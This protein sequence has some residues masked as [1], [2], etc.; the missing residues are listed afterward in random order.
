M[1]KEYGLYNKFFDKSSCGVGFITRKDG[2]QTHDIIEKSH[3]ALCSV[4]HRGGMS[5]EGVG[6]GA[7]VSIDL[8]K[9]FFSKITSKE[10]KLGEFCVGNFF[11][12]NNRRFHN[13]AVNLIEKILINKKMKFLKSRIIPVNMKILGA[14][15]RKLQLSIKQWI[16]ET[17]KNLS[18]KDLEKIT[19]EALLEIEKEAFILKDFEGLY[20]LSLSTKTQVLK[21]RLNSNELI[22]YFLDLQ[23]KKH[24][25]SS[26]YFHTRFSTNT[27][28][29]P[30]M[31]QPFRLMAHNGELN[32]DNKNR[33]S[34]NAIYKAK[35]KEIIR[36]NGQSDSCRFDQTLKNRI[37]EDDL[38][39]VSAIVCMMPP[40]WENNKYL[41]KKV[42]AMFEYFSLYEEKNDGPAAVIFGDGKIVGACLDRLGL[43]PLR[44]VET[45]DYISVMS[46]SGQIRFPESTVIERGRIEAGGIRY[47]D[48][49]KKKLFNTLETYELL[50]KEKDYIT[51]LKEHSLKISELNKSKISKEKYNG[52][53]NVSARYVAYYHNQESLKF[54]ID[55]ILEKGVEKVSAMGYGNAINAL[56]PSEG[57]M[58]KYFSHRFAQVTNPPLDPIRESD[59]MSLRVA[60]GPK[61]NMKTKKIPQIVLDSPLLNFE[62]LS[63]IKE[64]KVTPIKSFD[65]TF[66]PN[67]RDYKKNQLAITNRLKELSTQIN[68]FVKKDGGIV[69]L[70]DREIS[71]EK[72]AI[73][74]ILTVSAINQGLIS[75]GL[76]FKTSIIVESGQISSPHHVA[77]ALGFGGS[78]VYSICSELRGQDKF[79]SDLEQSQKKFIKACEKSL[80]KI[81]G[82]V[83]LC[84]V[85]S[86]S[87]GEFFEPN[88]LNTE[89]SI[90]KIF[91]PNL[92]SPVGGVG[93]SE[94]AQSIADW[95]ERSKTISTEKDIP[96][97]GLFK[98]RTE[99]AGHSFGLT[100]VKG[101]LD[102]T[103]EKVLQDEKK[104][105]D[106]EENMRLLTLNKMYDSFG[107]N[108]KNFKNTTFEKLTLKQINNFKI[109]PG[110]RSFSKLMNRERAE[111]PA[112]LR[113]ILGFPKDINKA[114]NKEDFVSV[115]NYYNKIGNN[116]Y[117]IKNLSVKKEKN[118][119]QI[120]ICDKTR[121]TRPRLKL[122]EKALKEVFK[123]NLEIIENKNNKLLVKA[124]NNAMNFLSKILRAPNSISLKKVQVAS[125][126]TKTFASGA[127]SHGA[128]VATAHEAIAHGTNMVGALSNSG[129]GGEHMS[130]YGTIRAS[131]IKQLASG[132][133][134]VWTGYLADP[135]LQEIE[136]KIAQGAKPGEG[137]QL[138]AA[139]VTVEIAAARN[140]TPG[141]ELVSPPP[142]HDTYSIED[143]AQLIHD[144]KAARV[145]VIVKLVSSVGIGTIAVGVAKAGADIINIAGGTGG[146][147][148]ANVTSLKYA[149][150]SAEI[151]L[152]E[153]HQA[154]CSN[155]IRDKVLLRCSGAH[156]T[157]SDVI[158]SSLLGADSFEFGTTAMM[159]MKCV[160]AKN[161]NIKCPAG[162]TT[163]SE[164]FNGDARVLAQFY[165]NIAH[166]V[167]EILAKLGL[168]SLKESRGRSD[169]L[170][171]INTKSAVG[172]IKLSKMLE[173]IPER[174]IKNPKYM[175]KDY[176]FDDI[177]LSFI[178][179]R[180]LSEKM[181]F[182]KL[183]KPIDLSNT[184]KTFAGQLSIDLE[185][186]INHEKKFNNLKSVFTT[187]SGRKFFD[188]KT[189]N[190]ATTGSA[191]QSFGAFC[192]NGMRLF[193][194]G[195]CND[196]VGK[197]ASGGEIIIK[198][199]S[200][201]ND[202]KSKQVLVGNFALFGATGGRLFVE[203]EAG[204]RF[205]VRNSGSTAVVEGV[206]EYCSEYMTNGTI[207][208][209]GNFSRGFG[210]G[211]SGG[212]AYQYDPER[213]LKDNISKESVYI[214]Y[215]DCKSEL[216][217][218][219][220]TTI[221]QMLKWHVIATKSLKAKY[222]LD[223]WL[224]EKFNMAFIT[225]KSLLQYQDY[226]E[227]L[228]SK[229]KED[230]INEL[231]QGMASYQV[232]KFKDFW[233]S[234]K[235]ILEGEIPNDQDDDDQKKIELLNNWTVLNFAQKIAAKRLAPEKNSK[236][237]EINSEV[238]NLVL[239]ENFFL[240]NELLKH[241][242]RAIS[243]YNDKELSI[244]VANKR[245]SD[246][247]KA[248]TMRSVL[249]M[250]GLSTY[251]W[252]IYQDM[253][254]S[255]AMKKVPNYEELF[256]NQ[257]LPDLVVNN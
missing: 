19:H 58:A 133:F 185:R 112:A 142:H 128:L 117:S 107:I 141:V 27:D 98:E 159:M 34:E 121:S 223:N 6:D 257:I 14:A 104:S 123:N 103:E 93:F 169:L 221:L 76:R 240:M 25:I 110:Y 80:M 186:M 32:T 154:L 53:L 18:C 193:H 47:Y 119:F 216:S 225:P 244:M 64:Q 237:A 163:N 252:I 213:M 68:N 182:I 115:F 171:L 95:H 61:V 210:N 31:A 97:I 15:A 70:T 170:N 199:P 231:S 235:N 156:Q 44:T 165:L 43:R 23:D 92:I 255:K 219:H 218:M 83:G 69:V 111:K 45:H 13:E 148:A 16:F 140:G 172:Q 40:A 149:G 207:L 179:K 46:E 109:T 118:N 49:E 145:K 138:P 96:M 65:F 88:Y 129:E 33:L 90:L 78:A 35:Q 245:L 137:G 9:D 224:V 249:S 136:I 50:S 248:L 241:S 174:K 256:Y 166:E 152:A 191:G 177:L 91:F 204:D 246:F 181:E 209:I 202:T 38:D 5:S 229:S 192:N 41:S 81:M 227:I 2:K 230:L 4:P 162:I 36:P 24:K 155:N 62:D 7:G 150:R 85:E 71:S 28:P 75:A 56:S 190:I 132:R 114:Q 220:E 1:K 55:P 144:A 22:P 212:F 222:L 60:L 251:G 87:G 39:I 125:E 194:V 201:V 234:G 226:E 243:H 12:P 203:G 86:Y 79:S 197:S 72:A 205:A 89:D 134:G 189:I 200:Q 158:K 8:S 250:D 195:T 232:Q 160:M 215:L 30:S 102:L 173:I 168:K 236:E 37:V 217:K 120:V 206:G 127:M 214:R 139:K 126:I 178:K 184:N 242:K 94:I 211:M 239:T 77:C 196:G 164:V 131:R 247:K 54:L 176:S 59:G 10:L 124:K 187:S 130:R 180:L 48:H 17:P 84:T 113:D 57:G 151:G 42:R 198:N 143:L 105:N 122:L 67:Y 135:M 51:L 74:M 238:K 52:D 254:N 66:K 157:G 161:C 21:G 253:R 146:T 73:P 208:N 183:S 228:K 153:V 20:P 233:H 29:H 175:E 99:G 3:E 106:H 188:Q 116:N 147:G 63:K 82:K 11:L 167:R 108:D 101:F 100:A 26:L